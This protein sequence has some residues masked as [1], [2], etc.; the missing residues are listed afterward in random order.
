MADSADRKVRLY[1]IHALHEARTPETRERFEAYRSHPDA[2]ARAMVALRLGSFS[3]GTGRA[4]DV[5]IALELLRDPSPL[6]RN[7]AARALGTIYSPRASERYH[8]G[9][10][11]ALERLTEAKAGEKDARVL[12]AIRQAMDDLA[13]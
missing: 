10:E 11:R 8:G 9:E 3:G 12:E 7:F 2:E 5:A 1:V 13:K 6:V 4:T